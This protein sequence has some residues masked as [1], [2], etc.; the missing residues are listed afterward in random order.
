[1]ATSLMTLLTS[2]NLILVTIVVK[3]MITPTTTVT[4]QHKIIQQTIHRTE[5]IHQM[6]PITI[7]IA[8]A[9]MK[10]KTILSRS[11]RMSKRTIQITLMIK[12][13]ITPLIITLITVLI[14]ILIQIITQAQIIIPTQIKTKLSL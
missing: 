12:T 7:P 4:A 10:T 11:S 14:I 9:Q 6:I 13:T 2:F 8:I 3:T 5:T 1:M